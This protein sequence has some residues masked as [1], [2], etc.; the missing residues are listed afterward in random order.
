V[1][2][3]NNGLLPSRPTLAIGQPTAVDPSRAPH[4][5]S[6]LWIQMQEL[7]VRLRGDAAGQIE[8]PA[9]GCWTEAVRE[10]MADRVQARLEQVMPGLAQQ[11]VGRR[12]FGPAD[13]QALNANLVGGDPY[14]GICSPDQFFWLRPFAATQG[15]RTHR[16]P[17]RGLYQIGASTHP[18][19]GLGAG[20][21]YLVAQALAPR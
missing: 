18:G 2:E 15:A 12:A 16:T 7:P 3:A 5:G 10:A 11:V 4:G 9:D 19:P 13:L 14:S 17:C 21:G 6:I 1:V 8:V 20:S